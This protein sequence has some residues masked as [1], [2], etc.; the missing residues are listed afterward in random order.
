MKSSTL[1]PSLAALMLAAALPAAAQEAD[2]AAAIALAD[3]AAAVIEKKGVEEACKDFADPKGG[4]IQ[5]QL[6]VVVQDMQ[7]KMVCNAAV[8]KMNGKDMLALKDANGKLFPQAMRD[9]AQSGKGG[10]VDYVWPNPASGALENKLAYVRK[11]GDKYSLSVG[12]YQ[13]K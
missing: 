13:K 11:A 2:K 10:W 9:V 6:Y 4:Y 5:G 1:I 12:I 3:K 8:P 7:C